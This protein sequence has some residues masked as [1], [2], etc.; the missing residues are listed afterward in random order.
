[1]RPTNYV[2]WSGYA[3]GKPLEWWAELARRVNAL[4]KNW[5]AY[6]L[7]QPDSENIE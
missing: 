2:E 6:S 7:G 1:M 4:Q 5:R 3:P